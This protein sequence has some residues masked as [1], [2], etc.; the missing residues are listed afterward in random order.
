MAVELGAGWAA[1]FSALRT[2][3][4]ANAEVKGTPLVALWSPGA[5]SALD[6]A[7]IARGRDVGQ[8]AVYDRRVGTRVLTFHQVQ[9]GFRDRE[10]NPPA[11]P[12]AVARVVTPELRLHRALLGENLKARREEHEDDRPEQQAS[13]S[14]RDSA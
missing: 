14:T 4:V 10:S 2:A 5:A 8:T 1:P 6:A 7:E 11:C 9:G 3:R 12:C 13:A